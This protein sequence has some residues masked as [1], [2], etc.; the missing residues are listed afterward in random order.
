MYQEEELLEQ[1]AELTVALK[2]NEHVLQEKSDKLQRA[3]QALHQKGDELEKLKRILQNREQEIEMLR[4]YRSQFLSNL[5]HELRTP[6]NSILMLS[7]MFGQNRDGNLSGE[8]T[9]LADTI[10]AAGISLA[11][12]VN[13]AL[14]FAA[15]DANKVIVYPEEVVLE[16]L[17]TLLERN[18]RDKI[19]QKGLEFTIELAEDIP[20]T[21]ISDRERLEHILKNCLD[22][23]LKFTPKGSIHFAIHRPSDAVQ[24]SSSR[25][26]PSHTLAF[27]ISDTGIG[28]PSEKHQ[29][30]F[31]AFQQA[32]SGLNRSF[33]GV[34]LGLTVVEK[35]VHLLGGEIQLYSQQGKGSTFTL[36]LP[37][38]LG[39]LMAYVPSRLTQ[40]EDREISVIEQLLEIGNIRD[41]RNTLSPDTFSVLIIE[42]DPQSVK[43]L[44]ACAHNYGI[45]YLIAGDGEAGLQLADQF[46]PNVIFL[47]AGLS[48][49]FKGWKIMERLKD[50][51]ET[52]HIPVYF[53]SSH[54]V[55]REAVKIGAFDFLQKPFS[56]ELLKAVFQHIHDLFSKLQRNLVILERSGKLAQD[57]RNWL[58]GAGVR[59]V[60]PVVAAKIEPLL[61]ASALN[62]ILVNF[63]ESHEKALQ[64]LEHIEKEAPSKSIPVIIYSR[65]TLSEE[66]EVHVKT[67]EHA[68]IIKKAYTLERVLDEM[69]LFLYLNSRDLP[70][71]QQ[72]MLESLHP[73]QVSLKGKRFLLIDSDMRNGFTLAGDLEARGAETVICENIREAEEYLSQ[74][75]GLDLILFDAVIPGEDEYELLGQLRSVQQGKTLPI[76]VMKANG[77]RGD[78]L[79]Y[80]KAG[81]SDFIAKPVTLNRLISLLRVWLY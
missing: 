15:L 76:I 47:N 79:R 5:S 44:C 7:E 53:M 66:Q 8:Q 27:S 3:E 70:E 14:D 19:E 30:I 37:E 17:Q 68:F 55:S 67:F 13:E 60:N 74:P 12:L 35:L 59:V 38:T 24:L 64:F 49:G 46:R 57:M 56:E 4:Q 1:C 20:E 18:F 26:D 72:K 11:A 23:A 63:D 36:Y 51:F 31:E 25:L 71:T 80:L 73:S 9:E 6:L 16:E 65:D 40:A 58:R 42:N 34:G 10:Y 81:A 69:S 32:E 29:Q 77:V 33:E 50:N 54:N 62:C 21:I 22:N 39:D 45:K 43:M 52:R 78:R 41:H 48:S 61:P 28:I 75:S 2:E